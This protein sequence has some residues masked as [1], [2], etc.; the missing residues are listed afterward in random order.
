MLHFVIV[1]LFLKSI[2]IKE[3]HL[4]ALKTSFLN[5]K[6][7]YIHIWKDIYFIG[8][9]VVYYKIQIFIKSNKY[10]SH[11]YFIWLIFHIVG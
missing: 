6:P 10:F 2:I 9:F 3:S 8:I 4:K 5:N 7:I 11:F 1:K